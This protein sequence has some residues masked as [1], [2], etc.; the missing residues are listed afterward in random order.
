MHKTLQGLEYLGGDRI[1][2]LLQTVASR[3][4][5]DTSHQSGAMFAHIIPSG[6]NRAA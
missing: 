6:Q 4:K 2:L 5:R 3:Q 1:L